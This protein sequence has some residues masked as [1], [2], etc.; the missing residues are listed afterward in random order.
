MITLTPEAAKQV[1]ALLSKEDKPNLSLRI[2]VKGGGCSGMSYTMGLEDGT[3]KEQDQVFEQD[4][5]VM[6]VHSFRR[7]N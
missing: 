6:M 1:K 7:N 5:I 3:P 2:G 4:G